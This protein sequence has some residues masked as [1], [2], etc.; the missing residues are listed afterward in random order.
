MEEGPDGS[1]VPSSADV[2][3]GER[4]RWSKGT[5]IAK[6]RGGRRKPGLDAG[7]GEEIRGA[8]GSR[9]GQAIQAMSKIMAFSLSCRGFFW[10]DW[11]AVGYLKY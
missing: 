10:G 11:L 9:S 7:S 4:G 8:V 2:L 5:V 1:E 6:A 3:Q